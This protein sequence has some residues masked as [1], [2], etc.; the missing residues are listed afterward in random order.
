MKSAHASGFSYSC[1]SI[2]GLSSGCLAGCKIPRNIPVR[3]SR[4][5]ELAPIS[6]DDATTAGGI[7][8]VPHFKEEIYKAVQACI[9]G[10]LSWSYRPI[11]FLRKGIQT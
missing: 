9:A 6:A 5:H 7:Q 8:V 3:Q 2:L 10:A 4:R 11:L 1:A